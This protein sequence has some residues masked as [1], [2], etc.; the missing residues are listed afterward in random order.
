MQ[1]ASK[2]G[3]HAEMTHENLTAAANDRHSVLPTTF[4]VA[5]ANRSL[6]LVRRIV[7]NIVEKYEE[8][9]ELRREVDHVGETPGD[10]ERAE[11]VNRRL[12]E[13]VDALTAMN[14]ELLSIGC[15]LKDWRTG[16]VD[17]PAVRHGRRVWLCWRLGEPTVAHWHGLEDGFAGRRPIGPHDFRT[18][19]AS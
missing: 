11:T 16:L 12:A 19:Q 1:K 7:E 3:L 15:V 2:K 17:F 18:E 9:V 10:A 8:L 4:T 5:R 6:V 14:Q 13:C